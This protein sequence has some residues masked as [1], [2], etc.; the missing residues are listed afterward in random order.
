MGR[1]EERDEQEK[2]NR[3]QCDHDE[4]QAKKIMQGGS[5]DIQEWNVGGNK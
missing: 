5:Y 4:G 1:G 3:V 2:Q